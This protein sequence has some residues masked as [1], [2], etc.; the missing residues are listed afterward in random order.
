M[1][2]HDIG[3]NTPEWDLLRSGKPTASAFS[4]LVTSTGAPS[5]S[6]EK[7]AETLAGDLYAGKPIDSWEGN[8]YTEYG[9]EMEDDSN[10]WYSM[11]Y[12]VEIKKVGFVTNDAETYGCSPDGLVGTNGGVE[13]KNLP[14]QHIK[15]LLYYKKHGKAPTDYY[16]QTQG[17]MMI[18]DWEWCDLVFY[19]PFLPKLVV[20]QFPDKDFQFKLTAQIH[21]CLEERDRVLSILKEF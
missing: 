14:K 1:K 10:S 19:H 4:N 12:D 16:Q 8:K 18:C 6:M 17:Q 13:F 15:T 7:Y 9:H 2:I 5:K 21:A 11:M 3:Q 20:R